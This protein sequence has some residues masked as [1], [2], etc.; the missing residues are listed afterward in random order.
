MLHLPKLFHKIGPGEQGVLKMSFEPRPQKVSGLA[1]PQLQ[2]RLWIHNE[3]TDE[4]EECILF[5]LNYLSAFE[6]GL[7]FR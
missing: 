7:L 3:S 2:I 1:E 6:S 4:N 5:N